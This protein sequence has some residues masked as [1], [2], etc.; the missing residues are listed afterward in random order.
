MRSLLTLATALALAACFGGGDKAE[1]AAAITIDGTYK[2]DVAATKLSDKPDTFAVKD[3]KYE[4]SSCTPPYTIKADG[5]PQPVEGRD[6][7]DAASIKVVDASTLEMTRYR[8]G[9]AVGTTTVSVSADG[10]ILTWTNTSADNAEGKSITNVAKSKRA[11]PAPAGAHAA[12][13]SWLAINDGAQIADESLT[14]TISVKDGV[15]SQKFPT[16]ESYEAKLGG[17]QVPLIGDKAG[18]TVAV[19]AEG[20]GFKETDYVNGKAVSELV[21][22]PVDATTIK[23]TARNLRNGSTEEYTLKKQ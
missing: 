15:V 5:T 22:D 19:V 4:C 21:F 3:G 8:K 12:S 9:T 23:L 17:P 1:T 18:A 11:G 14:A 20:D 2:A 7:W 10:Q 13:G 6:Y 16:G